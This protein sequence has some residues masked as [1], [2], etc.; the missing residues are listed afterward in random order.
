[1]CLS[2]TTAALIR[3]LKGVYTV[4]QCVINPDNSNGM[5]L[6]QLVGDLSALCPGRKSFIS[7][8]VSLLATTPPPFLHVYD[9]TTL[10]Y[11]SKLLMAAFSAL[12]EASYGTPILFAQM[13][14]FECMT[15]RLLFDRV[16]NELAD[17][18]PDWED[19]ASNWAATLGER[20]NDGL[21]DF[22]HGLRELVPRMT[23][24]HGWKEQPNVLLAFDDAERLKETLPILLT[25]L[26]R[27]SD[28]VSRPIELLVDF[29]HFPQ[30]NLPITTIFLSSLPWEEVRPAIGSSIYPY[31][32][33]LR[34]LTT[35]GV[36]FD[37]NVRAAIH[38]PVQIQPLSFKRTSYTPPKPLTWTPSIPFNPSLGSSI[39]PSPLSCKRSAP[40]IQLPPPKSPLFVRQYGLCTSPR[41]LTIGKQQTT[42]ERIMRF[43]WEHLA[44]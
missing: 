6:Q 42:E 3:T 17:W 36:F 1:L 2:Q 11:T 28:L 25:Q 19:G 30:T 8:L 29:H 7:D 5:E 31:V 22:V 41:S 40:H 23:E 33:T 24:K 35:E 13:S 39:N 27:L 9:P 15:P 4:L 43:R 44:G 20:Y 14:A 12:K 26:A 21:D 34:P 10:S 38:F 16:L 32:V 18:E 37:S